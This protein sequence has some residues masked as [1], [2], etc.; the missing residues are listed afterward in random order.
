MLDAVKVVLS[1]RGAARVL[2]RH[3]WVWQSD[4]KSLPETPGIH[5]VYGPRGLLGWALTNPRSLIQVRV[6]HF[7]PTDD[8]LA[9][10]WANL[11]RALAFRREAYEA[12][13]EGGFRL[14]HAEGDLLPGLVVDGYARHLVVQ[15][16]A[17]A[18]E[19]L[20]GEL[21]LRL[22]AALKPAGILAKHDAP[23]R[24]REGL[25]RYL[26]TLAGRVPEAVEV[27]E[28]AV[29]Y[30]VRLQGGQKTGAFLDQRDNRLRL[31][32][33]LEG[34]GYARAL[35]VFAYQGLFALHM[36]RHVAEVEAV[37]SSAAALEAARENAALNGL[38]NLRFTEANAFDLLRERQRAG[39]RY[40]VVVLDPPAF[41]ARKADRE[42]ALAAYKEVNLRALKLL[43]PG[44]LLVTASCSH[45]VSEADF[46]AMLASAAA[47]AHRIVRV[48]EQ[49]GQGWDHP[50]LLTVPETRYLKLALMEV[51][52]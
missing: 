10:L 8:P 33:Y 17:A 35:D 9:A 34:R 7:G 32:A 11:E 46:Y 12:E 44:G 43:A 39:E 5:P 22:E 16:H 51:L 40:D 47:D 30:R 52:E 13:P 48:R 41:A 3:P 19:P 15:A 18:W 4:V 49:R 6:F 21:T 2:A 28:G 50:V 23:L 36:A 25:E 27:R 20:L 29:R 26:R 38:E 14:V 31:E 42:R 1:P 24:E 45:H 37:D